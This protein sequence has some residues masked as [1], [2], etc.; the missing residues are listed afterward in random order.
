VTVALRDRRGATKEIQFCIDVAENFEDGLRR[1]ISQAEIDLQDRL[2]SRLDWRPRFCLLI[3]VGYGQDDIAR[4]RATLVSLCEQAYA[5]WH[6]CITLGDQRSKPDALSSTPVGTARSLPRSGSNSLGSW[7]DSVLEGLD[8]VADRI[9]IL[10]PSKGQSLAGLLGRFGDQALFT[11][12]A[13]GDELGRDALLEFAVISGMHRDADFFYSDELRISP[14]SKALEPFLKPQW[15]PDLLLS[16]NY[17]GRL[18]CAKAELFNRIGATLDNVFQLGEYDLVLRA[19]EAAKAIRHI[20]Q[21]L[22]RRGSERLDSEGMERRGLEL[23]M[24][25]RGIEGEVLATCVSGT[26]RVRRRQVA[27][28][29]VSIIIPTRAS[30]GLIRTCIETVRRITAYRNFEILCIDNIADDQKVW[31]QW[32]RANSDK[33]IEIA[34]PF[35]WSRY[36][37]RAVKEAVGEF[38]LFL[39]D[40]TEI[41]ESDWLDALLE[42]GQRPDVGVVGP[43]LLW[44][45]RTIQ[46]AG[47]FLTNSIG[48]ERH[49]FRNAAEDDPG[50]FGL[51]STQRNVVAING[52]CF[53]T[54]RDVF[55][56]LGGFNEAHRVINNETDY[57]L[58]AWRE[59]LLLVFTPYAKLIH[60]ERA[61][62]QTIEGEDYDAIGFETQWGG[63]FADGDPYHHRHLSKEYDCF[64]PES[65]PLRVIRPGHPLV[66]RED[67]RRILLVKLDHVG[68]CITAFPAIRRL[69]EAFPHASLRVLAGHWSKPIWPLAEM[70]DEIIEFDLFHARSELG[71]RQVT[72]AELQSLRLRLAPYRFDLAV[73][74]RRHPD[75]RHILQYTGARFLAGCDIRGSFLWLDIA[76]E[77][78]GDAGR[79]RKRGHAADELV[80]L[81]DTICAACEPERAAISPPT[82]G[83]LPVSEPLKRWLLSRRLVCV[84]PAAGGPLKEWPPEYFAKLIDMLVEREQVNVV[85]VGGP[86]DKPITSS[87]L[88]SVR[89]HWAVIDLIGEPLNKYEQLHNLLSHCALFIGNDSGPKHLAAG[90]GVPTVGIHSG[91][92]DAREWGPIGP[93]AIALQRQMECS[94]CYLSNPADCHRRV[95]CMTGLMPGEVYTA[96]KRQLAL[97]AGTEAGDRGGPQRLPI[98]SPIQDPAIAPGNDKSLRKLNGGLQRIDLEQWRSEIVLAAPSAAVALERPIGVFVHLFYDDLAEEIAAYLAAIGLAKK[99]YVSTG[100]DEKRSVILRAFEKVD[101][102]ASLAQ[103]AIVPD[104]GFDIAPLLITFI[105]KLREHDICLKIHSKKSVNRSR[106]YGERWRKHLYDELIGDGRRAQAIVATMLA[107]AQL[108][109]LMAEHYYGVMSAVGIIGA[110]YEPM[111]KILSRIKVYLVPNQR[112]EYP[113]GSMFWFR[114]SAL[115]ELADLDF[116]WRDFGHAVDFRDGTLA[117][118]M[119]RCFAFFCA[120]ARKRWGILPP[121]WTGPRRP[122]EETIRLIRESGAF[123]E[124]YYRAKYP[125]VAETEVDPIRHWVE[126]GWREARNPSDPQHRNPVLYDLLEG[127]LRGLRVNP[128]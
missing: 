56:K 128:L 41:I 2:L 102:A 73:D 16:T 87:V 109:L 94:P 63:L 61:T 52:A 17:I 84:H 51:A 34:E 74:L 12:V 96:C 119:E 88:R 123:D 58:K 69:K 47:V 40:D 15:S 103:I 46:S 38:L 37:N 68:D 91:Q 62:R 35:N 29:L 124:V 54:R 97:G 22:C 6:L 48:H 75:T 113:S 32:L 80:N 30:R 42:H 127:H 70:I 31:K 107:D 121:S 44:P 114:T 100:S 8:D 83:T 39:N 14:V 53:M 23:A 98:E 55:E 11:I 112:I 36:N 1:K 64:T 4:A 43:M 105:D 122:R 67:I 13:P 57:C 10:Q 115:A 45:D 50:Y 111:Q 49:A 81:A 117:H 21:L 33:V 86:D 108:G 126:F 90:L 18:W 99:I 118:G 72:E 27:Q 92:I 78:G 95:A 20:P 9:E 89:N 5:D 7:C 59:G 85:L 24:A 71:V 19:T 101:L 66:K 77:W 116:D 125:D 26:Y 3:S 65:E 60:Y 104:S 25:R 106:E 110:N 79:Q 120:H 93:H 82:N 28:G 76:S